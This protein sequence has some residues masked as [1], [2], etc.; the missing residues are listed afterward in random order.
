MNL[1]FI[2]EAKNF[3]ISYLEEKTCEYETKHPWRKDSKFIILHSLR[4]H[5]Y[6]LK[7]IDNEFKDISHSDKLII[8]LAAI[9][10][11]IGKVEVCN[12]HAEAS[13]KIVCNWLNSNSKIISGIDDWRKLIRIIE[14]HSDK[15][16]KENDIC[17]AILKDADTLDEIGVLSIF[18]ASNQ[19]DRQSPFF[20]NELLERLDTFEIDFCKRKIE[21]LNTDYAKKILREKMEFIKNF[22]LQLAVEIKGTEEIWEL[23]KEK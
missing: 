9:L 6:V 7:I 15:D 4:V 1:N 10:H 2:E 8:E 22:N 19:V 20:F 5:S 18:M 12:E 16:C 3:L 14:T 21:K 11:D 17:S 23:Y 13:A